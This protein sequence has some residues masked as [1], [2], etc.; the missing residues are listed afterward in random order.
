MI[1]YILYFP[2]LMVLKGCYIFFILVYDN[3]I[4]NISYH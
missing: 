1:L 3:V 2:L 4:G